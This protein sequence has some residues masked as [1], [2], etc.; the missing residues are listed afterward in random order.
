MAIQVID[1]REKPRFF[2]LRRNKL[3]VRKRRGLDP[4]PPT[5]EEFFEEE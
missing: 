1:D 2:P 4:R 3:I 5:A